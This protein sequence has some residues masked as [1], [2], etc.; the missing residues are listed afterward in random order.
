MAASYNR[1]LQ[2]F[3][4]GLGLCLQTS[5]ECHAEWLK[6]RVDAAIPGKI[7]KSEI[8]D[9]RC[10]QKQKSFENKHRKFLWLP[11][12]FYLRERCNLT[13]EEMARFKTVDQAADFVSEVLQIK[14]NYEDGEKRGQM[15]KACGWA[16][17]NSR[18]TRGLGEQAGGRRECAWQCRSH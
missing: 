15:P 16:Q 14:I 11:V 10:Y 13:A 8:L 4:G 7:V 12:M 9:T 1:V 3:N 5:K 17:V 6:T 2:C 18:W